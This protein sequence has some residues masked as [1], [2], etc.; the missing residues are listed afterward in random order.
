MFIEKL[1]FYTNSLRC[2]SSVNEILKTTDYLNNQIG[3]RHRPDAKNIWHDCVGSLY[4]RKNDVQLNKESE[5]CVW[6]ISED[7]FI[8]VQVEQLAHKFNFQIGRVRIMKL[9]PFKGLSVHSD[10]ENRYHLVL[11]TNNYSYVSH[12]INEHNF[13]L[14]EIG[15]FYHIPNNNYWYKIK[16]TEKHWVYNGGNTD[17]IHL[18]VCET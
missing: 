5:F 12:N 17:R 11:H 14:K 6:S 13:E 4:D 18:V 7:N 8:R 10:L 15:K 3:L 9:P 16:T 2:L 1:D